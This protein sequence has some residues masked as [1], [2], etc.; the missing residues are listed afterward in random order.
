MLKGRIDMEFVEMLE[1]MLLCPLREW[2][3]SF[4]PLHSLY[5]EL[6]AVL[7]HHFVP[8]GALR[9]SLLHFEFKSLRHQYYWDNKQF[10]TFSR[11]PK[12]QNSSSAIGR[13]SVCPIV[14]SAPFV[15][16]VSCSQTKLSCHSGQYWA[17]GC[18]DNLGNPPP[19]KTKKN[20][21]HWLFLRE[22][23]K[24]SHYYTFLQAKTDKY[25][26]CY[27]FYCHIWTDQ[28]QNLPAALN[29]ASPRFLESHQNL[30]K[31][32][33]CKQKWILFGFGEY[34][35]AA[36]LDVLAEADGCS[37]QLLSLAV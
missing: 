23:L 1:G 13:G 2:T 12:T 36:W 8:A 22:K 11:F 17:L 28:N 35:W 15:G 16:S 5:F 19:K 29:A 7:N 18:F 14:P 10:C 31:L 26:F 33:E 24:V 32:L 25:L 4:I 20:W 3:Y 30:L 6:F 27:G 34:A 9:S 37:L 21:N